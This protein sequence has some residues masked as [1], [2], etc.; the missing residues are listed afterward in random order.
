MK[1]TA[2]GALSLLTQT[3]VSA[4]VY[5]DILTADALSHVFDQADVP[6]AR[7]G[8]IAGDREMAIWWSPTQL[9]INAVREIEETELG[10]VFEEKTNAEI[11]MDAENHRQAGG[12]RVSEFTLTLD[13]NP[14]PGEV[15]A[16]PGPRI[17]D[18]IQDIAN[19][20]TV[21]VRSF[22]VGA[23]AVLWTCPQT[24]IELSAGASIVLLATYPT[25]EAIEEPRRGVCLD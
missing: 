6:A 14:G 25:P 24:P 16:L 2:L 4:P 19:V 22:S 3:D 11:S 17:T 7:R 8:T 13:G 20:I 9:A 10:F 21:P 1:L 15:G 5:T 23:E 12:A 18:P